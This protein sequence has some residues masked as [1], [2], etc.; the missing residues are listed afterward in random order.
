MNVHRQRVILLGVDGGLERAGL[1]AARFGDALPSGVELDELAQRAARIAANASAIPRFRY[2]G[3]ILLDMFHRD[4]RLKGRWL[5]LH[6]REFSLLWYFAER[7]DALVSRRRLLEDVWRL[8]HE[9]GTNSV[10]VHMSRL[11]AKL[12]TAGIRGL[13]VTDPAGGYRLASD[14][15]ARTSIMPWRDKDREW[16]LDEYLRDSQNAPVQGE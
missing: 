14:S 15:P 9:P 3:E 5:G 4:A 1:L 2:V 10:E 12:A 11:R 16:R 8:N 7:P 13:I 6:P